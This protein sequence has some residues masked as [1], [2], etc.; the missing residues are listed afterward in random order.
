MNVNLDLNWGLTIERVRTLMNVKV[1][2]STTA[3]RNVSTMMDCSA[4]NVLEG[5]NWTLMD[6]TVWTSMNAKTQ[7]YIIVH[8]RV[9]TKMEVSSVTVSLAIRCLQME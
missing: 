2:L 1:S 5:I 3:L 8:K 7:H 9:G 6:P 4:A